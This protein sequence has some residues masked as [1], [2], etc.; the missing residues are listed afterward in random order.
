MCGIQVF[1]SVI[2]RFSARLAEGQN[3][4]E[5]IAIE[6]NL[7]CA[8]LMCV[9]PLNLLKGGLVSLITILVYKKL[10]PILKAAHK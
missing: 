2:V 7:H 1:R 4:L 5:Q 8:V 10:S 9:V 3:R 6:K